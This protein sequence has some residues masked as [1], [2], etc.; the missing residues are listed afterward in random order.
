[1]NHGIDTTRPE[2]LTPYIP[3]VLKADG[4]LHTVTASHYVYDNEFEVA[5]TLYVWIGC[6]TMIKDAV[7][8]GEYHWD[9]IKRVVATWKREQCEADHIKAIVMDTFVLPEREDDHAEALIMNEDIGM[10]ES[11]DN[12]K[13]DCYWASDW[14][15]GFESTPYIVHETV[16]PNHWSADL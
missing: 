5:G 6:S 3:A 13:P 16:C 7:R 4:Y 1:M 15:D 10:V 8:D 2:H 11:Y 9:A 14:E 12:C